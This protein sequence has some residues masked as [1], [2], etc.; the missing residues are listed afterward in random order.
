VRALREDDLDWTGRLQQEA[1]PHGFFTR[2]G[3][4]FL[5]AYQQT[6]L[7]SPA[8]I[9]LAAEH[10][11]EPAGFL[12][13]VTDADEHRAWVVRE[14]RARLAVLGAACLARRP[15]AAARFL[16]TRLGHYLWTLGTGGRRAPDRNGDPALPLAAAVLTHVAVAPG[17]RRSGAGRRL[18]E[19]FVEEARARGA[20]RA[21]LT[22]LRDDRGAEA[23]WK[24]LG[25]V[26]GKAVEDDE[27]RL[28][29]VLERKL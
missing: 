23:F 27:D 22:T 16:R 1:L 21:R 14:R 4:R 24:A 15:R 13:G 9:A 6:F 7:D 25:W 11:G 17:A 19:A 12:L 26:P 28:H 18:V 10:E 2:L 5:R 29:R 20:G 8:G 3:P